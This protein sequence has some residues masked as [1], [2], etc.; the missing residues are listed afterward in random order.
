MTWLI[1]TYFAVFIATSFGAC[2]LF[3]VTGGASG[4]P[5]RRGRRF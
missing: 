3:I 2:M 1:T 4:T 5:R